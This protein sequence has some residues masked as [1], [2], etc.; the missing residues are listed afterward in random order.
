QPGVQNVSALSG[1]G[2]VIYPSAGGFI[3][4][5]TEAQHARVDALVRELGDL[6]DRDTTITEFYKLKHA[7]AE[8]AADLINSLLTGETRTGGSSAPLFGSDLGSRDRLG[9]NRRVQ[10]PLQQQQQA[11]NAGDAN[12]QPLAPGE[13]GLGELEGANIQ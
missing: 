7:K 5:G 2:F 3:Y 6:I 13:V 10:N 9:R 1:S 8:E 11:A 12:A 4:R